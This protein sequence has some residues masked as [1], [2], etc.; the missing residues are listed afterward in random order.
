MVVVAH[1]SVATP[2]SNGWSMVISSLSYE[3]FNVS[4]VLREGTRHD[5]IFSK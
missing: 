5:Y 1:A 4:F 3:H 2:M